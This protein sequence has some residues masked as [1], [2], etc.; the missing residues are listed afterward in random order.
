MLRFIVSSRGVN[1]VL[2]TSYSIL[3]VCSSKKDPNKVVHTLFSCIEDIMKVC[4]TVI[5]KWM[6][7]SPEPSSTSL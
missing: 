1:D 6:N 2:M 4:D 7:L 5:G 3:Y